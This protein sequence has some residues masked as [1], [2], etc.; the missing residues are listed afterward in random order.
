MKA[1]QQLVWCAALAATLLTLPAGGHAEDNRRGEVLFGLCTQ[2]HGTAGEGMSFTLAPAIA[3]L[4]QWYVEAQLKNFQGGLRGLHA[5]DTA[6]LRMYPMSLSL[7][8]DEDV[9]AV[10]AYVA[11]LPRPNPPDEL[12]GGDAAKGAASYATCAACHGPDGAGNK[13]L[14]APALVGG[15]DWYLYEQLKKFKAG[16][17]G[18]NPKNQNA[19]M[20]RGMAMSLADDQA[21][22]DVVAH[23]MTLGN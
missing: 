9:A 10:A 13:D 15:S 2:C 12:E 1:T 7:R 11:N 19:V 4:G 5:E 16:I 6:G 8:S 22:R 3:G 17:R 23:I 14:N 21:M 20:M 18:G